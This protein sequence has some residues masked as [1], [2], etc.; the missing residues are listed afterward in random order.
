MRMPCL[1]KFPNRVEFIGSRIDSIHVIMIS[2]LLFRLFD[3]L[4]F[5]F[6]DFDVFYLLLREKGQEVTHEHS[7]FFQ[8]VWK[9]H[10]NPTVCYLERGNDKVNSPTG[11]DG[12]CHA[13]ELMVFT[14]FL[15][16]HLS[17]AYR[18]VRE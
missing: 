6:P 8:V 10:A 7:D 14:Q 1:N 11:S 9:T 3:A 12:S 4:S 2:L 17:T 5:P 15:Q 18:I 13:L 16:N